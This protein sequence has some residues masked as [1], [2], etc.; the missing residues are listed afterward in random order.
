M[1]NQLYGQDDTYWYQDEIIQIANN[2]YK[3]W[4]QING[5][6]GI[7]D[8]ASHEELCIPRCSGVTCSKVKGIGVG[9]QMS[10]TLF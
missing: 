10:R 1:R 3:V 8:N 5:A 9:L 7:R 6:E 4:D 2:R